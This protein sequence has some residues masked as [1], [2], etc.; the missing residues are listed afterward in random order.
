[1]LYVGGYLLLCGAISAAMWNCVRECLAE[2]AQEDPQIAIMAWLFLALV[3]P[4]ALP[5]L[6][7]ITTLHCWR[8][9]QHLRNYRDPEMTPVNFFQLD[10]STRNWF[11]ATSETMMQ[12]GFDLVGDF[13]FRTQPNHI[14]DRVFLSADRQV[15]GVAVMANGT[16][17]VAM[18]SLDESGTLIGSS[19]LDE[20]I[21]PEL[22]N[23]SDLYVLNFVTGGTTAEVYKR[24]RELL[25]ARGRPLY[26]LA[27]DNCWELLVFD[28]RRMGQWK[29]RLG[30]KAV[31]PPEPTLPMG[32]VLASLQS[33]P[34]VQT[35]DPSAQPATFAIGGEMAL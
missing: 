18:Q 8:L 21:F 32:C 31:Q 7:I 26:H 14:V 33:T 1:M 22:P 17:S 15:V 3:S 10:V 27:L 19:S 16:P 9:R 12:L 11:Q 28:A 35:A 23:S 5:V 34:F 2:Q 6:W 24:H 13:Q 25:A 30:E 4:I 20:K 29:H